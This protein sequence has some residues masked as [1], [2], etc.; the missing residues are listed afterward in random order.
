MKNLI[1]AVF[2]VI[3]SLIMPVGMAFAGTGGF[4]KAQVFQNV[5][6]PKKE[7]GDS[8]LKNILNVVFTWAGIIA[9]I[10]IMVGGVYYVISAGDSSKISR[11]KNILMYSII[12]LLLVIFASVIVNFVLERVFK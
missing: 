2:A 3:I 5:N 9:V 8:S 6:I 12:G 10:S 1:F 7:A 11:A 4:N